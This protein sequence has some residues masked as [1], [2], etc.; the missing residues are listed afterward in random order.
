MTDYIGRLWDRMLHGPR[1]D[2]GFVGLFIGMLVWYRPYLAIVLNAVPLAVGW[3]ALQYVEPF[4]AVTSAVITAYAV[5]SIA[6]DALP[7][8]VW[9]RH[10]D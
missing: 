6:D 4:W 3:A 9:R 1:R 10:D 8:T 7:K 2:D 5:R